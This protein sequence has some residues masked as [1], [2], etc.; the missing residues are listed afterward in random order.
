MVVKIVHNHKTKNSVAK[1]P[2]GPWKLPLI[3]NL[4]QLVGSLPHHSLRNLANKYGPL[5]HLQLGELANIVVSSP[6]IAKQVMKT[7][8]I[9]FANRPYLLSAK[10]LSYDSTNIGFSPYGEYWRQLRKICSMELLSAKRVQSFRSAREEEVLN[11]TK[12]IRA[13][14]GSSINLSEKISSTTYSITARA[15]FG[16]RSNDEKAFISIV[17]EISEVAAGFSLSDL[18][19]SL[20]AFQLIGGMRHRLE[21]LHRKIDGILETII[22]DHKQKEKGVISDGVDAEED[23]VD[24]LLRLQKCGDLEYP[25]TDG[26]IKAVL[27]DIF[28]A[29]SETSST[30][31]EWTMSELLKNP[32]EMEKAQAE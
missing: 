11:F 18:Y 13:S 28:S 12:A 31:I 21:K 10:I 26:N 2:P 4:H 14:E 16:K 29:G 24:V 32:R 22:E 30:A 3:G 19:P 27:L 5:M 9:I 7:H 25:L 1:C 20:K 17:K 23:L 15:A 8:D 6:E